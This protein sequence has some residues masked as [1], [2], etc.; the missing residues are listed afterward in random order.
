MG[1]WPLI[2]KF[3]RQIWEIY[4]GDFCF[5]ILEWLSFN[6]M[7][8]LALNWCTC[9]ILGDHRSH[10]KWP[11]TSFSFSLLL[12]IYVFYIN[13][14]YSNIHVQIMYQS[15]WIFSYVRPPSLS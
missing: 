6:T 3:S 14:F 2:A 5:N 7:I 1:P 12:I 11:T 15:L 10:C 8:R 13:I 9:L 4:M